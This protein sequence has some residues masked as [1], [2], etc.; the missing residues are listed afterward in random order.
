[1]MSAPFSSR[2]LNTRRGTSLVEVLVVI[3]VFLVGILAI[4][5]IFPGGF[6][7]LNRTRDMSIATN[8]GRDEIERIKARSNQ[9][10]DMILPVDYTWTGSDFLISANANRAPGDLGPVS[11]SLDEDGNLRDASN[12]VIG[13]WGELTGANVVR[14]VVGESTRVPAPRLLDAADPTS[15]G[16]LLVLQFAPVLFNPNYQSLLSVFGNDMY[17]REGVPERP[18]RS[19]EY[20]LD[21]DD[22]PAAT[23]SV[24]ADRNLAG[25]T[26]NYRLT[27]TAYVGA[28]VGTEAKTYLDIPV[29]AAPTANGFQAFSIASFI[30]DFKGC[31]PGSVRVSRQFDRVASFT[32]G[33][34][35]EYR[36]LN[37]SLGSLLFNPAGYDTTV[38]QPSGRRTPLLAR[39][40]YDVLDWRILREDFRLE[41]AQP[42]QKKLALQGLMIVGDAGTDS[43]PWTGLPFDVPAASGTQRVD[44]VVMD[45]DTGG[46]Y[47]YDRTH[48]AD[49]NPNGTILN[50]TPPD[51][52][53]SSYTVDQS[54]GRI[55]FN[56]FDRDPS[57]GV[58]L[59]L[60]L[61][62]SGNIITVDAG[63]RSVR[64]L[65][66]AR[67][68]W[69]VQ[70]MKAP[71][72]YA[73]GDTSPGIG[74]YYVG[75]SSAFGGIG[76]RL[77]FPRADL[78]SS[79]TVDEVY[80][81]RNGNPVG[82]L[83]F[84]GTL[85]AISGD[86]LGLPALD[87]STIVDSL[88]SAR[89]GYAV[90]GVKGAS[91]SVRVLHNPNKLNLTADSAKNLRALEAW[92]QGW[93]RSTTTTYLQ[94]GEN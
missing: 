48:P 13:K 83:S 36:V 91:L 52:T 44:L 72:V 47:L 66:M 20:Y 42:A 82:P 14:R 53:K 58:Q 57:N 18:L 16:G 59:R 30:P 1:M 12:N 45:L 88:D 25:I 54:G 46:V 22:D 11:N 68:E 89:F 78:G 80:G 5:Q 93:R 79:I 62:G 81:V 92:M 87:L 74:Q 61:P 64:A 8:L 50:T 40:S 6:R 85:R 35:Y 31:D 49:P 65:Y 76:T 3:V 86:P 4:V 9:M 84:S 15:Y 7:I 33:N 17:Q 28:G 41:D 10:P 63:G 21:N 90:R 56:D 32:D 77:Y 19:Y 39:V 94:R 27:L 73:R 37:G 34:P 75:G 71:S 43:K 26:W 2:P 67:N 70:A 55:L 24:P 51:P 38:P 69:A 23:I 29:A 60:I